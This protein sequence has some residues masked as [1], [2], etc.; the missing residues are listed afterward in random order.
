MVKASKKMSKRPAAPH[1]ALQAVAEV[2]R[3]KMPPHAR[4][5][6]ATKS[7]GA[8]DLRAEMGPPSSQST[9]NAA[10]NAGKNSGKKSGKSSVRNSV[11]NS[12]KN[13]GKNSGDSST[14][15]SA[16]H[17]G[18]PD[19]QGSYEDRFLDLWRDSLA[20]GLMPY[21]PESGAFSLK[22]ISASVGAHMQGASQSISD[23]AVRA[24]KDVGKAGMP[25]GFADQPARREATNSEDETAGQTHG[26]AA[27]PHAGQPADQAFKPKRRPTPKP[28][29]GT[30][31]VPRALALTLS[32]VGALWGA[33][34]LVAAQL[35]AH[36]NWQKIKG[37]AAG[38]VQSERE[39]RSHAAFPP[40][41][42][43]P[44]SEAF[45]DYFAPYFNTLSLEQV[46]ALPAA[47]AARAPKRLHKTLF[48]LNRYMRAPY[49]RAQGY[50]GG[51]VIW[52]RGSCTVWDLAAK[53][54]AGHPSVSSE[55]GQQPAGKPIFLVPSLVNRAYILDL[56]PGHSFTAFLKQEGWRPYLLDW[57]E[58]QQESE[59]LS[60]EA[61][62]TE[63]LLPAFDAACAHAAGK[64]GHPV[65]RPATRR[66]KAQQNEE[67]QQAN[68]EAKNERTD[69]GKGQVGGA[70][71]MPVLGYCMG[72]TLS[73]ALARL[74]PK[75]V[76]SLA[77]LAAPWDMHQDTAH[78]FVT[79]APLLSGLAHMFDHVTK[80]VVQAAMLG[81][82]QPR[83]KPSQTVSA[84][85]LQALFNMLDPTLNDRK[86]SRFAG[87]PDD[88]LYYNYFLALEH[89]ANDGQ[90][91]SLSVA[92]DCITQWYKDNLTG[93]GQWHIGGQYID[94]ALVTQPSLIVL[95]KQD[96]LVS[97]ASA[98]ALVHQLPHA[99]A[100]QAH[101]GHVSMVAGLSARTHLWEP[102]SAWLKAHC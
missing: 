90:D 25:F 102:L 93:R 95:P 65:S 22:D 28:S 68:D 36:F 47:S 38:S 88:S 41:A 27:N 74:R 30:P 46:S 62:V 24:L 86:F 1:E 45:A 84:D 101:G 2:G 64:A 5:K 58:P 35:A 61:Y 4:R 94:P 13:S 69:M 16:H 53:D 6:P 26:A 63:R 20:A 75:S 14:N 78:P 17:G 79:L 99:E 23:A 39:L 85:V 11:R 42:F 72:G 48:G 7:Q 19:P 43:Q 37:D 76:S 80:E 33:S 50:D 8:A 21:L 70:V 57:G 71:G 83:F 81:K 89:W 59:A 92:A 12:G 91:L 34:P 52:R 97:E 18:S 98:A 44:V 54:T 49:R 67:N 60:L 3:K 66:K 15:P 51:E 56:M 32:Q 31:R 29:D 82:V 87:V 55:Q 73:V 40:A 96:R 77:L 10:Q 100:L 9:Q